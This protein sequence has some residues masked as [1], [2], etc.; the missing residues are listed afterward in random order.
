[1]SA[2]SRESQEVFNAVKKETAGDFDSSNSSEKV[3]ERNRS[4]I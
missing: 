2:K 4:R 1:M 3:T